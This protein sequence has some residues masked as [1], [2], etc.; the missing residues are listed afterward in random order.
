VVRQKVGKMRPVEVRRDG[1]FKQSVVRGQVDELNLG[2]NFSVQSR[3][4]GR[5]KYIGETEV[6]V[7]VGCGRQMVSQRRLTVGRFRR[8][9]EGIILRDSGQNSLGEIVVLA[10]ML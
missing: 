5:R 9:D 7:I 3:P 1:N 4:V 2:R 8:Q 10:A 6:G